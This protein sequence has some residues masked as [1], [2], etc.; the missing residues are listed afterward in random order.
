MNVGNAD[1][2]LYLLMKLHHLLLIVLA[3]GHAQDV[4]FVA[5]G[6]LSLV[7]ALLLLIIIDFTLITLGILRTHETLGI[8]LVN[9]CNHLPT[10]LWLGSF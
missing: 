2:I 10:D 8:L 9:S 5:V 6:S 1:L 3:V 4:V 7:E